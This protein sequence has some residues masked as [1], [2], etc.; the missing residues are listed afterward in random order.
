VGPS[1][2]E[3]GEQAVDLASFPEVQRVM[4]PPDRMK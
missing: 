4:K 2:F 3:I 1:F